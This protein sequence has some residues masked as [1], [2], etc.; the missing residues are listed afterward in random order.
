MQVSPAGCAGHPQEHV[1]RV[2]SAQQLAEN[3]C[4]GRCDRPAGGRVLLPGS[5]CCDR[6]QPNGGLIKLNNIQNI[7]QD[8]EIFKILKLVPYILSIKANT[9]VTTLNKIWPAFKSCEHY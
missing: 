7:Q 5:L 2:A 6:A 1:R 9:Q 3:N 4:E 8:F